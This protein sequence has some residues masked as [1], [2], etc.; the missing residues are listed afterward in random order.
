MKPVLIV[1][2]APSEGPGNFAAWLDARGWQ[3]GFSAN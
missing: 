3:V 1:R 2:H